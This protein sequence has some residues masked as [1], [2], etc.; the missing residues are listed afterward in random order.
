MRYNPDMDLVL[1]ITTSAE[2]WRRIYPPNRAPR[3]SAYATPGESARTAHEIERLAPAWLTPDFLVPLD[4]KIHVLGFESSAR[5]NAG[6]YVVHT[7][8]GPVPEGSFYRLS[9]HVIVASPAFMFLVAAST[10]SEAQL[11]AFGCELCG[12]Y[13]FDE[14]TERGFRKR[15]TP[16]VT[17]AHLQN[18]LSGVRGCK[19]ANKARAALRHVVENSA[20]PMETFDVLAMC[21][22]YRLGGYCLEQ[23]LMN[24]E[25]PL[26]ARA[27]RIAKRQRCFA[28]M[29][30][31]KIPLDIEHH[32]K[33]DHTSPEDVLS[34]RARVNG[35][36]EMGYEVIE[37]TGEQVNDLFAFEIIIQRIAKLMGKR[38]DAH[39][40]GTTP[41]R[42]RLRKELQEWNRS[43]GRLR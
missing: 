43:S 10:L 32:G 11:I 7:W 41:A 20:S 13:G 1:D 42:L 17:K 19:G 36:K 24:Y 6:R 31:P 5:R 26:N 39:K 2:F 38:L 22:P 37:L 9:D 34:D 27:S 29:C 4:S 18:Y 12:L 30:Y 15:K 14:S 35:L 25:V 23:P 28:D 8:S 33:Y 3:A 21:L 16:L 40:L